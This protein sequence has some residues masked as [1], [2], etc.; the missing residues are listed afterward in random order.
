VAVTIVLQRRTSFTTVFS[1]GDDA[2]VPMLET[3]TAV[4]G[5]G[6]PRHPHRDETVFGAGEGVAS[7][8]GS[9]GSA[10]GTTESSSYDNTTGLGL[11]ASAT[12]QGAA[13][14]L[15]PAGEL[16]DDRARVGAAGSVV[17]VA[18]TGSAAVLLELDDAA[19]LELLT[20]TA[21]LGAG[22]VL[23]PPRRNTVLRGAY[24]GVAVAGPGEYA[25]ASPAVDLAGLDGTRGGVGASTA[26]LGAGAP[27]VPF[28]HRAIDWA[29][30]LIANLLL[31]SGALVTTVGSS[32]DDVVVTGLAASAA[33]LGALGPVVP[34]EGA[35]DTAGVCVAVLRVRYLSIA[36][37]ATVSGCGDDR[38]GLLLNAATTPFGAEAVC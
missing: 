21:G 34:L 17:G 12:T 26:A 23:S 18:T 38:A 25:A 35:V 29:G 8:L 10:G 16:A 4:F 5:T 36:R 14:V 24:L 6:S 13:V 27:L 11:F 2:T 19:A 28:R 9:G 20:A 32:L 37:L 15:G 22:S 3:T 7:S 1:A 30:L 33:A 31:G